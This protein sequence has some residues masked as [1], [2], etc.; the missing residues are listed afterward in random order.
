MRVPH[1]NYARRPV[2]LGIDGEGVGLTGNR[3]NFPTF[4]S[5]RINDAFF[6]VATQ[7]AA[8]GWS[9]EPSIEDKYDESMLGLNPI[10]PAASCTH[11]RIECRRRGSNLWIALGDVSHREPFR[12][13]FRMDLKALT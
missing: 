5:N 8:A 10:E 7:L 11:R 4:A 2:L 3:I 12:S 13:V 6:S 9:P 1:M